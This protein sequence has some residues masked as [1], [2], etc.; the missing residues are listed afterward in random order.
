[1]KTRN[2]LLMSWVTLFGLYNCTTTLG[3]EP[4]AGTY[5]CWSYNVSGAGKRCTSPPLVL[6]SDGTYQMSSEKGTYT[7]KGKELFLSESKI[8]GIGQLQ[9]GR[10][11]VFEYQYNGWNHRVTYLRSGGTEPTSGG[12]SSAGRPSR[13]IPVELTIEFPNP[14]KWI[15]W[16]NTVTLAPKNS[17]EEKGA[18]GVASGDGRRIVTA[19]LREVPADREYTLYLGTGFE[20]YAVGHVD[21][22]NSTGPVSLKIAA[23]PPPSLKKGE[24]LDPNAKP[25]DPNIPLYRQ[26]GCKED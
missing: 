8:R 7:V 25:C 6:N 4:I 22:R 1:M 20:Q 18:T 2:F 10:Q 17:P 19:R 26:R 5:R 12:S 16:V 13:M 3:E 23:T 21:L 11:I 15:G 14:E 24:N 9:D